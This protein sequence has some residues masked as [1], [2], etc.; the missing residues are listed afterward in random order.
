MAG[1][2]FAPSAEFSVDVGGEVALHEDTRVF[3]VFAGLTWVPQ[4]P[5]T[6]APANLKLPS[7][8]VAVLDAP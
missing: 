2:S 7:G 4:Q 1:L 6:D 8:A 3:T 5:K